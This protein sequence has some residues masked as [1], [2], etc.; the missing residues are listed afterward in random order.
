[1]NG[2][3]SNSTPM[4]P[5]ISDWKAFRTMS[6]STDFW[7]KQGLLREK[8]DGV[9]KAED[10][11]ALMDWLNDLKWNRNDIDEI[12][13]CPRSNVHVSFLTKFHFM[14]ARV[15]GEER[16]QRLD[17]LQE[18]FQQNRTVQKCRI[19]PS[20]F[21]HLENMTP[22]VFLDALFVQPNLSNLQQLT[23]RGDG[24]STTVDAYTM[25][26]VLEGRSNLWKVSITGISLTPV[27]ALAQ[28]SVVEAVATLTSLKEFDWNATKPTS[29]IESRNSNPSGNPATSLLKALATLP[30]LKTLALR[31]NHPLAWFSLR[32]NNRIPIDATVLMNLLAPPLPNNEHRGLLHLRLGDSTFSKEDCQA[33]A[34]AL[35][36]KDNCPLILLDL[37]SCR[38]PR[39]GYMALLRVLQLNTSLHSLIVANASDERG[40]SAV[41]QRGLISRQQQHMILANNRCFAELDGVLVQA[42]SQQNETLTNFV[43]PVPPD[44]DY[45]RI[46]L[47][48]YL[49]L[50]STGFRQR[51]PSREKHHKALWPLLL[52]RISED[53]NNSL[54]F[55][56]LHRNSDQL[57]P[58]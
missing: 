42:L 14:S 11:T 18:A 54:V 17:R 20:F 40:F 34:N 38:M 26:K 15:Q 52:C 41:S 43:G 50:N 2:L 23:I 8:N 45:W 35:G 4:V 56:M 58:I 27:T 49:K 30:D 12:D 31:L 7:K 3:D 57:F 46:R 44:S 21:S 13:F 1:M 55:R 48:L 29:F 32:G 9:A 5:G 25:A 47:R 33:L 39:L 51:L 53:E 28:T 10:E 6:A 19:R 22:S 24:S 16:N 36:Q 37:T